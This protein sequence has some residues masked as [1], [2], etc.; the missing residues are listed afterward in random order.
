[1]GAAAGSKHLRSAIVTGGAGGIGRAVCQRLAE[2]GYAVVVADVDTD[3][4]TRVAAD[5]PDVDGAQHVGFGG[6]LTVSAVNRR[7]AETAAAIA[8][9][10]VLVN[11]VGIS[12]KSGGRKIPFWEVDDETW[13]RVLAVNL[14]APFYAVRETFDLMPTDGSASIVNIESIAARMGVGG[15]LDEFPPYLPSAI[16]YGASK[17]GLHNLTVSL[18]RELAHRSIRVNGVAPGFVA[19]A[20]MSSAV[21]G[22]LIDQLPTKRYADPCEV[23]DA[24][25]YL[26]SE[27]AA[28]VNGACIDVNGGWLPA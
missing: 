1:M 15:G 22:Q 11:G 17:A 4:A 6:D 8:P 9:I 16:V 5:L 18:V 20:M 27:R 7:M 13:L 23:A 14:T 25:A 3:R 10:G 2:D 28:Y 12:P 19:T 24:V 26:V 21:G